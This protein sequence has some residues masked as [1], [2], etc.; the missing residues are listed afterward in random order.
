MNTI[1]SIVQ[2]VDVWAQNNVNS[3]DTCRAVTY[4]EEKNEVI[5]MLE[6]TSRDLRPNYDSVYKYSD[7]NADVYIIRMESGGNYLKGHN[8]NY[9]TASISMFVGGNSLFV[10]DD[11]IF[12]G[13][14]SWGFKTR[15]Q[16][17]TYNV[18]APTFDSHLIRF[19]P[20]SKVKCLYTETIDKPSSY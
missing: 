20:S 1:N 11:N 18:A 8:L 13:S 12:F 9:G 16:N 5:Y 15:M 10:Q 2:F 14:Y 4:D 7:K 3:K 17:S 19:D 6:V